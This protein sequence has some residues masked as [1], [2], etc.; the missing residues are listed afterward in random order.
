MTDTATK[1]ALTYPDFEHGRKF[2]VIKEG[3]G[4]TGMKPITG[5]YQGWGMKIAVGTVLTCAGRAWTF[6]DGVPVIKWLDE[7]GK[8]IAADCEFVPSTGGMWS[9]CPDVAYLEAVE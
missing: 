6:G 2:R 4:L 5:G 3:A 9:R 7:N 1:P 8:F